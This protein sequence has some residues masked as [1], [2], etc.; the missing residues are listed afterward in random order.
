MR[1]DILAISCAIHVLALALPMSLLQIYDRIL[2]AQAF[3]TT[4]VLVIGVAIALLLESFLRYG[5]NALFAHLGAH[6]EADTRLQIADKLLHSDVREVERRGAAWINDAMRAISVLR[7]IRTGNAS[8]ALY[9]IPF[10]FIYL[11]IIAYIGGWLALIPLS[12]FA[13]ALFANLII[14]RATEREIAA[15]EQVDGERRNLLWSVFSGLGYF[16]TLGMESMLGHQYARINAGYMEASTKLQSTTAWVRELSTMLSQ[17]STV[18]I[19]A[20]GALEV[21][22]GTLTTGALAACSMLAGRSIGPAFAGLSYLSR[23]AQAS[24]AQRRVDELMTLPPVSIGSTRETPLA[25][26]TSGEIRLDASYTGNEEQIATGEIVQ[27]V[28]DDYLMP[29]RLL[30]DIAGFSSIEPGQIRV[31]GHSITDFATDAYRAAVAL[32]TERPALFY[33]SILNNMTLFDARYNLQIR[34]LSDQLG[35]DAYLSTQRYG[36]LTDVGPLSAADRIDRGVAQRIALIRALV[37]SPRIL[38]LDHADSGLD[39]DGL[40]RLA[41]RLEALRGHTTVLIV[42]NKPQIAAICD[43]TLQLTGDST[44]G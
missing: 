30:S 4:T 16:K 20:F 36:V 26:V 22:A 14:K 1:P 42:T 28:S 21:M 17:I 8:V 34:E 40:K 7:D 9:E 38:L 3:G 29:S 11:G 37:R 10:V 32:V 18:L 43:R 12:L 6:Y 31:D 5:R 35:L 33:G 13:I 41:T 44:H 39:L 23:L 19:V 2:P 24:D 27:L 15:Q 25:T